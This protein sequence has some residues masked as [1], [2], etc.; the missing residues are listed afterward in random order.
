MIGQIISHYRITEK[1]G[2]G[3]MGEVYKADDLK[4]YRTVA[5]KFLPPE[6]TRNEDAKKRF[7]RE[8]QAASSLQHDNI[9]VIHDI[10]ETDDGRLF[11]C[12]EYY[13]GETLGKKNKDQRLK[14]KEVLDYSVQI[15]R[16]LASAHDC[17]M[18]H[19]DIKPANIMI[20]K[21]DEVKIV[22]FGLA[23]L[24]GQSRIT[25]DGMTPG[26]LDYM[27]PEQAS[28]KPVDQ[29]TDIWSLGV[30]LYELLTGEVP[31][32]G[33][34][35][36]AKIYSII[37]EDPEPPSSIRSDIPQSL[38]QIINHA[39]AKDPDKRYPAIRDMLYDL[40]K[41]RS[42]TGNQTWQFVL[43]VI[44]KRRVLSVAVVI[45]IAAAALF[46]PVVK[47]WQWFQFTDAAY[48]TERMTLAIMVC[49]NLIDPDD[50]K[51]LGEIITDALITDLQESRF[52]HVISLQHLY[53]IL[54]NKGIVGKKIIDK[55]EQLEVARR[56]HAD[57]IV[58]M[59]IAQMG[60]QAVLTAHCID[61]H[62]GQIIKSVEIP[63]S[64]ENIY[65]MVD[66]LSTQ[67][68]MNLDLPVEA[69][70]EQDRPVTDVTT[71]S[72]EAYRY[73]LFGEELAAQYDM[74]RAAASFEQAV[75][76]DSTFASAYSS[77]SRVYEFLRMDKEAGEAF[78]KA[79]RYMD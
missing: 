65:D 73:Y 66:A 25:R 77:L 37:N 72:Y 52:V 38:N 12:M 58:S 51:R 79:I 53:D 36:Q 30:L 55:T 3:G 62:S 28:G 35:D 63:G 43:E 40:E 39:L 56:A 34:Y 11:I 18:I 70:R 49:E 1:L 19:R 14:M 7:V 46:N 23:R 33:E 13:K 31:F 15:A 54:K 68:R 20:T 69:Q 50:S 42:G 59:N 75:R 71:R 78:K 6:I 27:S 26:T 48:E 64:A 29:R 4:L 41:I 17:K 60:V 8:A 45:L 76:I 10:D 16:G 61:V 9:C 67:I 21:D 44:R 22:D 47:G 24:I 74:K 57:R 2:G 32:K 5:L